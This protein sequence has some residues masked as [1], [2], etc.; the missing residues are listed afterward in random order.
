V[1]AEPRR[2][3]G[4]IGGSASFVGKYAEARFAGQEH[5]ALIDEHNAFRFDVPVLASGEAIVRVGTLVQHVAIEPTSEQ[6]AAYL[7]ID[8]PSYRPGHGLPHRLERQLSTTNAI[9]TLIG[10]MRRISA[11][12]KRW[13]EAR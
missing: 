3:F 9:E 6:P 2:L 7:I 1:F 11:R 10:S 12:V 5:R 8:R 13:R 4:W